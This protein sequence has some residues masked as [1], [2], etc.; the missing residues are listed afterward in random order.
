M[1]LFLVTII[2]PDMNIPEVAIGSY[3]HSRHRAKNF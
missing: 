3:D 2:N 1:H